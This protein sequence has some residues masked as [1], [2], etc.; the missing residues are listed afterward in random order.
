M[1][2]YLKQYI[3]AAKVIHAN[4]IFA[5][6]DMEFNHQ[7]YTQKYADLIKFDGSMIGRRFREME[8]N[9]QASSNLRTFFRLA[10]F[11]NKLGYVARYVAT[12]EFLGVTGPDQNC[13]VVEERSIIDPDTQKRVGRKIIITDLDISIIEHV[14][15]TIM[16]LKQGKT[17]QSI[18]TSLDGYIRKFHIGTHNKPT[19]TEREEEIL[20]L[21]II[22][23][24]YKSIANILSDAYQQEIRESAIR[25]LVHRQLYE[26]FNVVNTPALLETVVYEKVISKIPSKLMALFSGII[27]VSLSNE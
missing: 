25:N 18:D 24:K 19:L 7:Y 27:S 20:F 13:Y 21:L 16:N 12:D 26:K 14:L 6:Q 8:I 1:D 2:K 10:E 15:L 23:E 9:P 17:G 4:D 11:V 3:E 22:G 5:I